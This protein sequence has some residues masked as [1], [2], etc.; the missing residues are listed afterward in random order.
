MPLRSLDSRYY[1]KQL[2]MGHKIN[3]ESHILSFAWLCLYWK[4][5]EAV[6]FDGWRNSENEHINKMTAI[7]E[8]YINLDGSDT[9]LQS[10]P[11]HFNPQSGDMDSITLVPQATADLH[12]SPSTLW[13]TLTSRL[14]PWRIVQI[15]EFS[16]MSA[17]E[18]KSLFEIYLSLWSYLF[19]VS[20]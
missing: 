18:W 4:S 12:T 15:F 3:I 13:V 2:N 8:K 14:S 20:F 1:C 6:T 16:L 5:H 10:P 19:F 7:F 11:H 9:N 17:S